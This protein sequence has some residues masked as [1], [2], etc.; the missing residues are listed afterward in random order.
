MIVM[1]EQELQMLEHQMEGVIRSQPFRGFS[2]YVNTNSDNHISDQRGNPG[3]YLN[4]SD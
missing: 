3:S 2:G 1:Q 4:G